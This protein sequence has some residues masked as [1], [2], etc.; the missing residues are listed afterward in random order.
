MSNNFQNENKSGS[1]F[2]NT[3]GFFLFLNDLWQRVSNA[4]RDVMQ[5]Q[6]PEKYDALELLFEYQKQLYRCVYYY[7]NKTDIE[8][9]EAI[10]KSM[11]EKTQNVE[12]SKA[13]LTSQDVVEIREAI[14]E[15][16]AYLWQALGKNGLL[17]KKSYENGLVW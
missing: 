9:I 4:R 6:E 15:M 7:L 5:L 1:S 16:D 8:K 10:I 13:S 14:E 17:P 2:Q 3:E 11:K 12:F